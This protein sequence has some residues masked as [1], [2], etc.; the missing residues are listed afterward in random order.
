SLAARERFRVEESRSRMIVGRTR[1]LQS[2]FAVETRVRD[3]AQEGN[4]A[5]HLLEDGRRPLVIELA[6]EAK[7]D[8]ARDALG[9]LARDPPVRTRVTRRIERLLD[10]L[11]PALGIRER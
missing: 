7:P 11:H 10:A 5:R 1:P 3:P 6:F 9:E 8:A 2:A 4:Q